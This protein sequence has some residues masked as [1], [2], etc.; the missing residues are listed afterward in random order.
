M[1]LNSSNQ[2]VHV[3]PNKELSDHMKR[4][5]REKLEPETYRKHPMFQLGLRAHI[6][7]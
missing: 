3:N 2:I 6:K 4:Q 7:Q 1:L 5:L